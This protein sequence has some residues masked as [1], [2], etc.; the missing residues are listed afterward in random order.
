MIKITQE[1]NAKKTKKTIICYDLPTLIMIVGSTAVSGNLRMYGV[2]K[3]ENKYI[4]DI[5][6]LKDRVKLLKER[7]KKLNDTIILMEKILK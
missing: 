6:K 2:T 5:K 4:I 3:E 1:L 7:R